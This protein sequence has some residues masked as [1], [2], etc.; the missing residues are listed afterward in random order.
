MIFN[1]ILV[2]VVVSVVLETVHVALS[3]LLDA[4]DLDH[5]GILVHVALLDKLGVGNEDLSGDPGM[6]DSS[7]MK[8]KMDTTDSLGMMGS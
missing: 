3:G 5:V 2:N 6:L 8:D 1:T 4:E 7:G